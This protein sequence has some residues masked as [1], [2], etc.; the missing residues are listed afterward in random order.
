MNVIL[1]HL[2]SD[3]PAYLKHSLEQFRLFNPDIQTFFIGQKEFLNIHQDFFRRFRTE[4]VFAEDFESDPRIQAFRECG[5]FSSRRYARIPRT[6]YPSPPNFWQHAVG[7]L[8]FIDCFVRNSKLSDVFHFENDVMMYR[9]LWQIK[10]GIDQCDRNVMYTTPVG[11][12]EASFSLF[13][14]SRSQSLTDFC[15]FALKSMSGKKNRL[16]RELGIG[17]VS[18]MTILK[19]FGD[20][21]GELEYF[22][23]LPRGEHAYNFSRF[24]SVFDGASWGQFLGGTNKGHPPGWAGRHHYVGAELLAGNYS[25]RWDEQGGLRL[26]FVVDRE[27]AWTRLNNLHIHSKRLELFAS[28][29]IARKFPTDGS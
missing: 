20:Q 13:F 18:D 11:P 12:R 23:V 27:G 15:D 9:D 3:I 24:Q 6:T 28:N 19:A 1:T 29:S 2:G 4:T 26:P 17:F 16:R 22:P 8:F 5:W 25:V 21:S 7:R 10:A 14:I